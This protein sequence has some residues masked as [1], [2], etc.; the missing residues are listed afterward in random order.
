MIDM[1]DSDKLK[2]I[3]EDCNGKVG[4]REVTLTDISNNSVHILVL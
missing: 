1:V 4:E 2:L 3:Q